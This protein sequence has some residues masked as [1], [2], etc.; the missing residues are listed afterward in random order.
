LSSPTSR[1]KPA[2]LV[3]ELVG[4]RRLAVGEVGGDHAHALDRRGNH[5][6][7]RIL[8][9]RDIA[10]DSAFVD[11]YPIAHQNTHTVIGLLAGEPAPVALLLELGAREFVV[12]QFE[13]LQAEDVGLT[14]FEPVDYMLLADFE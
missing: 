5:A 14:R 6:L 7:L 1:F 13:F 3:G 8:E 11:A 10:H 9:A 2:Q 12:G 4:A